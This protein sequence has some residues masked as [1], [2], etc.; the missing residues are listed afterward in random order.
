MTC[1][2]KSESTNDKKRNVA[3][4]KA[5]ACRREPSFPLRLPT[6]NA[7]DPDVS[8]TIRD[9]HGDLTFDP[10]HPIRITTCLPVS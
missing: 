9:L 4:A 7:N 2:F 3:K 10:L 5:K 8:P 1:H 6:A